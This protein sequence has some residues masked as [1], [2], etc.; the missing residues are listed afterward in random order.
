[1]STT[2]TLN[3]LSAGTWA[4][5]PTHTEV[6]FVARHLMVTKVRGSLHRCHRH[7][8]G[9]RRPRRVVANVTIK[10]ASVT[11]GTA[12]RDAHLRIE[13]F[14]ASE[15]F[16]D[17][18]FVSHRLRRRHP[19]GDLTIKGVTKPVTLDVEFNGVATDPWGNDK[20][21]F[22]ATGEPQPHRLGPDLER[23]PR[24]GRRPGLREDQA[25][26]RRP[27]REAGRATPPRTGPSAAAAPTADPPTAATRPLPHPDR[28]RAAAFGRSALHRVAHL[29]HEL[30]QD[31]LEEHDTDGPPS[32]SPPAPGARPTAAWPR[33]PSSTSSSRADH[34]QR[35]HTPRRHGHEPRGLVGVQDVLEVQVPLGSPA[36]STHREPAEPGPGDQPL[37]VLGRRG[38]ADGHQ[39]R[40]AR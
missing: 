16:P 7:R 33:A 31:V 10:T 21:A 26:P 20:A 17:M 19:R 15:N 13:D 40:A 39:R 8:R 37:D 9:L 5:D 12:D 14:F 6:G 3:G 18:T 28:G 22:E 25:R 11:T 36:S 34:R 35:P 30:L 1:M 38:A 29:A 4:I 24:E 32:S 2:S 23:Q 27:A